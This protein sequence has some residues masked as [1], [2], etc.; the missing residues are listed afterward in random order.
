MYS[1]MTDKEL[2]RM[3]LCQNG[4]S[5]LETELLARLEAATDKL[6]RVEDLIMEVASGCQTRG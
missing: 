1:H 6:D 4:L 5:Q 3:L 2:V